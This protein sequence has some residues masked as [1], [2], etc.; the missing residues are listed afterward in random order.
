MNIERVSTREE[1]EVVLKRIEELMTLDPEPK[2][3]DGYE[4]RFLAALCEGYE[5]TIPLARE[6]A[7]LQSRVGVLEV[8]LKEAKYLRGA[9][10]REAIAITRMIDQALSTQAEGE[11]S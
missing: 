7:S 5:R 6:I 8:A 11:K 9:E 2:S 4:L 1:N 10:A 3:E